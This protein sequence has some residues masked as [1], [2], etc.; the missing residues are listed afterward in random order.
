MSWRVLMK[1]SVARC[2]SSGLSACSKT[3]V[4]KAK[5]SLSSLVTLGPSGSRHANTN[6][7]ASRNLDARRAPRALR[8]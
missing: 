6:F 4:I 7:A 3:R 1:V 8:M 5:V 2:T